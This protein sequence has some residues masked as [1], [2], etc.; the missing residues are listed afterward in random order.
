[1]FQACL[2]SCYQ[3]RVIERCQCGDP[4][5]PL[6]PGTNVG[7]CEVTRRMDG[8][9]L[10]LQMGTVFSWA[11]GDCVDESYSLDNIAMQRCYCP[12]PCA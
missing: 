7:F 10:P 2:K 5:I 8:F 6:P 3:Q 11:L 12:P 4:R 1:M 9:A